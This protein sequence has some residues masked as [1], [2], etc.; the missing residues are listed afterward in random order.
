MTIFKPDMNLG[1]RDRRPRNDWINSKLDK[2]NKEKKDKKDR[3]RM[4]PPKWMF[5]WKMSKQPLTPPSYFFF[6]ISVRF[7]VK[8]IS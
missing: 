7:F 3:G 5:F 8:K 1:R 4:S 2:G 6:L